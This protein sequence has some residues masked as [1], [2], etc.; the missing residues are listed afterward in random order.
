MQKQ[1]IIY[2]VT[3]QVVLKIQKKGGVR[4]NQYRMEANVGCVFRSYHKNEL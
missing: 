2:Q 3:L 1:T 4:I